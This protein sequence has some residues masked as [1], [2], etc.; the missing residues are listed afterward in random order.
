[1]LESLPRQL[2][3]LTAAALGSLSGRFLSRL[4]SF[5]TNRANFAKASHGGPLKLPRRPAGSFSAPVNGI[6]EHFRYR[7]GTANEM[8]L[9]SVRLFLGTSFRVN[10]PDVLL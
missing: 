2:R 7:L 5:G 1:M 10:T 8:D 9:K 6:A 4:G 3:P